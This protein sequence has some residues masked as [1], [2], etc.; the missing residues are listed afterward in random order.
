MGVA[1]HG[2]WR[3]KS[4]LFGCV[5]GNERNAVRRDGT[6]A[7]ARPGGLGLAVAVLRQIRRKVFQFLR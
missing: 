5:T 6:G 1:R 3:A 4:T 2:Y 7:R